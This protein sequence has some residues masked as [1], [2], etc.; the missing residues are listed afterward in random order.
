[1]INVKRLAKL[2]TFLKQHTVI[3]NEFIDDFLAMSM[4]QGEFSYGM[5]NQSILDIDIVSKW[6]NIRK[7]NL[8]A[9]LKESYRKNIDYT[10][11]KMPSK[12]KS[13]NYIRVLITPDCFKRLCMR[14]R[15]KKSEDV[16]TYFIQLESM[17]FKYFE[18]MIE[19]MDAD[20]KRL[21]NELN[22]NKMKKNENSRGYLYVLKASQKHDDMLKIGATKDLFKRLQT[23]QTGKLEEVEVLFKFETQNFKAVE[24]CVKHAMTSERYSKKKE[25]YQTDLMMLKKIIESCDGMEDIKQ[26]YTRHKPL[27]YTGGFYVA[28]QGV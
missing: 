18:K 27:T 20:I 16:R 6:L 21:E 24:N 23:Y 17:L 2:K 10:V 19:G 15:S 26:L 14:S 25:I 3:P 1:M 12:D 7:D 28:L 11:K 13:N 5:Q 9:T 22:P 8:L 4:P